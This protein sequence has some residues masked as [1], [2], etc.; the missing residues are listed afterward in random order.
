[1]EVI[2]ESG[3]ADTA[4]PRAVAENRLRFALRRLGGRVNRARLRLAD[5]NGPRGGV[6]KE[7]R[8][9]LHLSAGRSL[10]VRATAMEWRA[11]IDRALARA[12][13]RLLRTAQ[14]SRKPVRHPE[15][16]AV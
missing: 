12:V 16:L 7:V 9:E 5:I 4:A 15:L 11:A 6:D 13:H 14:R 8:I 1:M 3:H 10:V 2:V